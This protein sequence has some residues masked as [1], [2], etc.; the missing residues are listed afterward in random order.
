M[1]RRMHRGHP[2]SDRVPNA[3]RL[4]KAASELSPSD[5]PGRR[6]AYF[7]GSLRVVIAPQRL[8]RQSR[9]VDCVA[10]ITFEPYNGIM[11]RIELTAGRSATLLNVCKGPGVSAL[12]IT[13]LYGAGSSST[14]AQVKFLKAMGLVFEAEHASIHVPK[15][16]RLWPTPMG[17]EVAAANSNVTTS[18]FIRKYP[19]SREW[20]TK[21]VDRIDGLASVYRLCMTIAGLDGCGSPKLS[22]YRTLA[23]DGLM[24]T[25]ENLSIGIVRQGMMRE[26]SGL[27][28]RLDEIELMPDKVL[29]SVLLIMVP[30]RRTRYL[31]AR[32]IAEDRRALRSRARVYVGTESADLLADHKSA[33]W[34]STLDLDVLLGLKTLVGRAERRTSA[35]PTERISDTPPD[36]DFPF[37]APAFHLT[38]D[39]K[40]LMEHLADRPR[41]R[42]E[43][44]ITIKGKIPGGLTRHMT[45]LRRTHG[46]VEQEGTRGNLRYLLSE[47]GVDYMARRDRADVG[48]ARSTWSGK[49][50]KNDRGAVETRGY[51]IQTVRKE[52][53]STD[54]LYEIVS[55]LVADVRD[56]PDYT[57]EYLLP[58]HRTNVYVEPRVSIRPDASVGIL[59]RGETYIQFHLEYERRARYRGALDRKLRPY[60]KYFGSNKLE[61]N[62]QQYHVPVLFVFPDE[63]VEERFVNM[64]VDNQCR[65]PVL[66]SNSRTLDEQG[67][68]GSAWRAVWERR[69]FS[70]GSLASDEPPQAHPLEY[71]RMPLTNLTRYRWFP[72]YGRTLFCDDKLDEWRQRDPLFAIEIQPMIIVALARLNSDHE[73]RGPEKL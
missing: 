36:D 11:E 54:G 56:R 1:L 27:E 29:P 73:W 70:L 59:H 44:L 34:Q 12:E 26:D 16:G 6:R 61:R 49:L 51:V 57:L 35:Y 31:V 13:G 4:I 48:A 2:N 40:M 7:H 47:K 30:C 33:H 68:L 14:Y 32:G 37:D 38:R 71:E 39:D 5:T 52:P 55:H 66:S 28:R 22:L 15:T 72:T 10:N 9:D 50:S 20:R 42:R 25:D 43:D 67:F 17:I 62:G 45:R 64:A 23:Y 19:V 3:K 41:I 69:G 8:P 18:E 58:Q 46:L 21:T 63:T 60:R 24:V 65:L 53:E